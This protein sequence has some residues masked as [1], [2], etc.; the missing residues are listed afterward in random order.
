MHLTIYLSSHQ[1]PIK[2]RRITNQRSD[3]VIDRQMSSRPAP[4]VV[5]R[6][7]GDGD[8]STVDAESVL[9]V[10]LRSSVR[11]SIDPLSTPRS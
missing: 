2:R 9:V 3:Q 10:R 5:I 1:T 11:T 8:R 7:S 4:V 6:T